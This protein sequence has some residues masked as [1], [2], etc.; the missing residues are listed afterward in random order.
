MARRRQQQQK[1][2][3]L[4][5][6]IVVCGIVTA[7]TWGVTNPQVRGKLAE[8]FPTVA[9]Q[10]AEEKKTGVKSAKESRAEEVDPFGEE[11]AAGVAS[12]DGEAMESGSRMTLPDNVDNPFEDETFT[13]K[14]S[15]AVKPK[16][17]ASLSGETEEL[18]QTA[19]TGT[20]RVPASSGQ[21]NEGTDPFADFETGEE[22]A[23]VADGSGVS[24]EMSASEAP[25]EEPTEKTPA[26]KTVA[27]KRRKIAEQEMPKLAPEE[28]IAELKS[29]PMQ[30][31]RGVVTPARRKESGAGSEAPAA[32]KTPR[33]TVEGVAAEEPQ[34]EEMPAEEEFRRPASS[35]A[36]KRKITQLN[37]EESGEPQELD[38]ESVSVS[39]RPAET[40]GEEVPVEAMD[41]G[42]DTGLELG[43]GLD[44]DAVRRMIQEGEEAK[45]HRILSE[46]YWKFPENRELFQKDLE[47]VAKQIYF[48][49][50]PHY[51][52]AYLIQPG[53]RLSNIAEEYGVSWRFLSKL[54][55]VNPKKIRAGKKLKVFQGPF[56]ASIDLSDFELTV[57]HNGLYVKKYKI[58]IGKQNSSPIGEFLVREKLE[59]PT[60]YGTDG[61][62]TDADDPLNPLGER[63]IDIGD[64]FGIHGTVD[65]KSIGGTHS[66]GCIRMLNSD[67]E[68][69]YDLLTIGSS[70]KIQR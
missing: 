61:N 9:K 30:K 49:P 40:Q 25:A 47:E 36:P 38:L 29:P 6:S 67:V 50:Q 11:E 63:W 70:V 62:V 48:S 65:P 34:I 60:Y 26:A 45:G 14:G 68:E 55:Q 10:E 8:L 3:M 7:I 24:E 15:A 56:A 33:N 23:A 31:S 37:Y 35:K 32:L 19:A 4:G 44:L 58:G 16:Q 20:E 12:L 41:S 52:E 57:H 64:G 28:P 42:D 17:T 5:I 43:G 53:D 51:E 21:G 1:S 27:S 46:W 59:N 13:A 66:K 54:N 39:R 2:G 18:M 22:A 69:V